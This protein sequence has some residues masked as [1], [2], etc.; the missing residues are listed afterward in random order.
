M[1]EAFVKHL[2]GVIVDQFGADFLQIV[3]RFDELIRM[4]DGNAFDVVH[5]HHVFGAQVGVWL[6][7]VHVFVV[8]AESF[9]FRQISRFDH[10][11]GFGFEGV[12]QFFD[13]AGEI[14]HLGAGHGFGGYSCDGA[15]DGHILCHGFAHARA[16]HFDGH[17]FSGSEFRTMHL[18]E[19]CRSERCGVDMVEDFAGRASVFVF[20]HLQDGAVRHGVG[21]GA[22]FGEFVAERLGQD[23]GAH[24]QDLSDFHES[25]AKR[26][27]HEPHFD[28]GQAVHNV[29]LVDDLRDLRKSLQFASTSQVVA[30]RE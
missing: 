10:E 5:D 1:E 23:F 16:L 29:E 21:V 4:R 18:R 2:R 6:R 9:E 15:H 8:L 19:A 28:G 22:Q 13:H 26:F 27:E 11:V 17:I 12:P 24:G 25:W 14:D 7:A 3:A 20:Q 30:L